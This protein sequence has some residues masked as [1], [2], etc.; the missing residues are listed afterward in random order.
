MNATTVSLSR[1]DREHLA[2]GWDDKGQRA[3]LPVGDEAAGGLESTTDDMLNYVRWQIDEID[4]A[5]RLSHQ[6]VSTA[7]DRVFGDRG[8]FGIGL[9]WQVA[10]LSRRRV[11][12]QDGMIEG[13]SALIVIEPESKLG[14]VLTANQFDQKSAAA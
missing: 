11:V 7:K 1:A 14:I 6:R 3:L 2:P 5:V 4:L 12:F 8:T 9:K 10:E 13:C